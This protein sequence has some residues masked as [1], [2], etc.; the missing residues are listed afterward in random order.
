MTTDILVTLIY[1]VGNTHISSFCISASRSVAAPRFIPFGQKIQQNHPIESRDF[2]SFRVSNHKEHEN[3]NSEFK[4]QRKD[5]IDEA[6]KTGTK[7]FF[8]GGFKIL[9]DSNVQKIIDKG[10][11]EEQAK[12]ALKY[13]K[14][15]LEKALG[16]IKKLEVRQH[17]SLN[18][19][20]P[21]EKTHGGIEESQEAKPSS[22]VCLFDFLENKISA[23]TFN[24]P[25]ENKMSSSFRKFEREGSLQNTSENKNK[26]YSK[27]YFSRVNQERGVPCS[28]SFKDSRYAEHINFQKKKSE[29]DTKFQ[30]KLP[31]EIKP[32]FK[33][34]SYVGK[35]HISKKNKE[36][37]QQDVRSNFSL[38]AEEKNREDLF[39]I[40]KQ[41]IKA[42]MAKPNE[43]ILIDSN[44]NVKTESLEFKNALKFQYGNCHIAQ[45]AETRNNRSFTN[46]IVGFQNKEGNEYAKNALKSREI[47]MAQQQTDG[48]SIFEKP[49]TCRSKRRNQPFS[50]SVQQTSTTPMTIKKSGCS[51]IA[52]TIVDPTKHREVVPQKLK[53]GDFCMAKYWED[54]Q[55]NAFP[56]PLLIVILIY[57][58]SITLQK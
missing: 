12:T 33:I 40:R 48:S 18:D 16:I 14:N 54:A 11:T 25:F 3:E 37:F 56:C 32:T 26:Q 17:V 50:T 36:K 45:S 27:S 42:A 23:T 44:L 24:R 55:V 47:P 31:D 29:N 35:N 10:Y 28:L 9:V 43:K 53:I 49:L 34:N 52:P 6:N 21:R 30:Q 8:G 19:N 5:A 41:K 7:K 13:S 58:F 2:K 1:A 38:T 57:S 39:S 51:S 46:Q 15:N 4:T 20:G 22:A